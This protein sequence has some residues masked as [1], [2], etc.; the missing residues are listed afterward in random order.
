MARDYQPPDG[1]LLTPM[2]PDDWPA[3]EAIYAQGIATGRATFETQVPTWAEFD[4]RHCVN[5]RLV[6]RLDGQVV[7][8]AAL[9]PASPRM[10]Y[11]GVAEVSIYVAETHRG[12]GIGLALLREVVRQSEG[13]GFWTLQAT[14]CADNAASLA[15]HTACGFRVVGRR[16][17]IAQL[18]GI[19]R[20]TILLERRSPVVGR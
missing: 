5:V 14:V 1:L 2:V 7:A 6:A 3:A 9:S 17:R 15:L 13:A 19:W 16:E 11:R 10:A 12:Q 18:G 8:W 4:A 20:D